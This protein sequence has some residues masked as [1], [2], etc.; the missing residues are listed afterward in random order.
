MSDLAMPEGKGRRPSEKQYDVRCDILKKTYLFQRFTTPSLALLIE[1]DVDEVRRALLFFQ[2]RGI[3][4]QLGTL[5][6]SGRQGQPPKDW[7][8][9]L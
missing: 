7:R 5:G 9:I 4:E 6:G 8:R 1:K 2:K 3:V